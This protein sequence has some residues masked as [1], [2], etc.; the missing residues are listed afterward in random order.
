MSLGVREDKR[1]NLTAKE[2]LTTVICLVF[3]TKSHTI[4]SIVIAMLN[5]E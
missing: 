3:E 4:C 5:L 1:E 2:Y